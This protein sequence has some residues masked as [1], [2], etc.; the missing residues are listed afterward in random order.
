[1]REIAM[2]RATVGLA[3]VVLLLACSSPA[4]AAP[5][6]AQP[7]A[8]APAAAAPATAASP[9]PPAS[10]GGGPTSGASPRPLNRLPVATIGAGSTGDAGFA[11]GAGLGYLAEEGIEME[12]QRLANASVLVPAMQR[13]DIPVAGMGVAAPLFSTLGQGGLQAHIVAEKG[14]NYQGGGAAILLVR[15]ELSVSGR[16]REVRDL[17]GMRVGINQRGSVLN[18]FVD[19][20]MQREGLGLNDL[21]LLVVPFAD[22]LTALEVG[23][24]DA[25][26]TVEPN[27]TVAED[28]GIAS[29]F[30]TG[31]ELAPGAPG[32]LV[33][34][35]DDWVARDRARAV[36][37][38]RAYI[39]GA[40]DYDMWIA[41]GRPNDR[42]AAVLA[43]WAQAAGQPELITRARP[44]GLRPDVALNVPILQHVADWMHQH[45]YLEAAVQASTLV[46][47]S[48]RQEALSSLPPYTPRSP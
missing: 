47:D 19:L 28:R 20:L 33:V 10:T 42:V 31:I 26:T 27:A 43:E 39:R 32:G 12:N 11:L 13:G 3:L 30:R 5:P 41:A 6:R 21:Q 14:S 4:P 18:F 36:G 15:R 22:Q 23:A 1:M 40:R 8:S 38:L 16:V 17:R 29:V 7:I 9:A 44:Y 34:M 25:S 48:L 35:M 2:L 46:D 24:I 45:G 37:F